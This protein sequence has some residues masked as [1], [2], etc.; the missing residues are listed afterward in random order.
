[1][2]SKS[3]SKNKSKILNNKFQN[4]SQQQNYHSNLLSLKNMSTNNDDNNHSNQRLFPPMTTPTQI[5]QKLHRNRTAFSEYQLHSL[6]KEFERTHYPDIFAREKLATK[7]NLPESRIQ[8]WFSNRRAKW[9]REEK[10]RN[11]NSKSTNSIN[12]FMVNDEKQQQQQNQK[13]IMN[14]STTDFSY[15]NNDSK[16]SSTSTSPPTIHQHS[17]SSLSKNQ[18]FDLAKKPETTTI[19]QPSYLPSSST[20]SGSESSYSNNFLGTI[21]HKFGAIHEQFS[22]SATSTI[23][24]QP[25]PSITSTSLS[26]P[27]PAVSTNS[28]NSSLYSNVY[29]NNVSNVP[30]I[31]NSSWNYSYGNDLNQNSLHGNTLSTIQTPYSAAAAVQNT[32]C[33]YFTHHHHHPNHHYSNS[34]PPTSSTST[35]I[36]QPPPPPPSGHYHYHHPYLYY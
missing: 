9:R 22:P 34:Q 5:T 11:I 28:T 16:S 10:F 12:E 13:C 27:P 6:E 29:N 8:V 7:I 17:N 3:S 31:Y 18:T 24:A 15:S 14:S 1:M 20:A 32:D 4:D 19:S 33:N 26:P 2:K 35:M 30:T 23:V 25:P 21:F 36:T